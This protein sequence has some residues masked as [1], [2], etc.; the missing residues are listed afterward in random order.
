MAQY[1]LTQP[2]VEAFLRTT[3]IEHID[4]IKD[5]DH[6]GVLP[7]IG[8]PSRGTNARIIGMQIVDGRTIITLDDGTRWGLTVTK[9]AS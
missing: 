1:P 2:T 6:D 3:I 4:R 8:D 7:H 5:V 9:E